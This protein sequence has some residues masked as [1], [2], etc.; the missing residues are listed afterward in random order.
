L[1]LLWKMRVLSARARV[2]FA[3][4]VLAPVVL[5]PVKGE[6]ASLV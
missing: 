2:V 4:V 3:P 5:A 6:A 1:A